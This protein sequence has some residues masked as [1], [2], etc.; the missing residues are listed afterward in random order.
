[1]RR[2]LFRAYRRQRFRRAAAIRAWRRGVGVAVALGVLWYITNSHQTQRVLIQI[3]YVLLAIAYFWMDSYYDAS[4][5]RRRFERAGW[6]RRTRA[7]DRDYQQALASVR[8]KKG[9]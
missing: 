4:D 2:M 6:R 7:L 5:L 3:G 9:T 8:A 1:M